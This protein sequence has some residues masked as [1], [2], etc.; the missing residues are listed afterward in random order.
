MRGHSG[1]TE[2]WARELESPWAPCG[3]DHQGRPESQAGES[4]NPADNRDGFASPGEMDTQRGGQ[5]GIFRCL[6]GGGEPHPKVVSSP[7]LNIFEQVLQTIDF[8]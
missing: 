1:S 6:T 5:R 7:S 4:S 2:S 3:S 8:Q